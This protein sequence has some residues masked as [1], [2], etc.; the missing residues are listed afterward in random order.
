[1]NK[2]I[3]SS[4]RS[5]PD[6]I[7]EI[8]LSAFSMAGGSHAAL[9]CAN[10][11]ASGEANL[12]ASDMGSLSDRYEFSADSAPSWLPNRFFLDRRWT[13][14]RQIFV[15]LVTYRFISAQNGPF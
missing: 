12:S 8:C 9:H 11:G 15:G 5:I 1:M 3:D 10:W 13:T 4:V 6:S 14:L 7:T 2:N